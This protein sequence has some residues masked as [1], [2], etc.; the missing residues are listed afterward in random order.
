MTIDYKDGLNEVSVSYSVETGGVFGV[1]VLVKGETEK[2]TASS[3]SS[4][5]PVE[6]LGMGK[7]ARRG[8][9]R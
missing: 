2:A 9:S 1:V 3:T 8:T 4:S 6:R 5:S 7:Q